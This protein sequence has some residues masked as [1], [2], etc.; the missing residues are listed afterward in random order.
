MSGTSDTS[1]TQYVDEFISKKY[2][3]G[4][5][6]LQRGINGDSNVRE[7]SIRDVK[8]RTNVEIR[9]R[10]LETLKLSEE[11][12]SRLEVQV[13]KLFEIASGGLGYIETLHQNPGNQVARDHLEDISVRLRRFCTDNSYPELFFEGIPERPIKTEEQGHFA[14]KAFFKPKDEKTKQKWK[15]EGEKPKYQLLTFQEPKDYGEKKMGIKYT[16]DFFNKYHTAFLWVYRKEA[17]TQTG[18]TMPQEICIVAFDYDGKK[19][20]DVF[21]QSAYDL[22]EAPSYRLSLGQD[23]NYSSNQ[24]QISTPTEIKSLPSNLR[25][26]ILKEVDDKVKTMQDGFQ[27][28]LDELTKTISSLHELVANLTRRQISP[29]SPV[30]EEL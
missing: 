5:K 23:G 21:S 10:A 16:K 7:N 30:E 2:R 9:K 29:I 27:K 14:K 18:R 28:T 15:E 20:W 22:G 26:E 8:T 4:V 24:K 3:S 12:A 1:S 17:R 19:W 6:T 25:G 13:D 11:V